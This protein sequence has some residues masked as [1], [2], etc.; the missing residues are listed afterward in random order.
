MPGADKLQEHITGTY[1]SLRIGVVVVGAALPVVLWLGGWIGDSQHL[2]AS[3]SAYYY[4]PTMG[5]VFVGTLVAVGVIL[6]LYKGFS[7]SEDWGLNLAGIFALGVA[8]VPM[9]APGAPAR[10]LTWHGTFA[11]LFFACIAYIC[12]FRAS[13]TLSLVR[14]TARAIRLRLVYRVLGAAMIGAPLLAALLAFVLRGA[15]GPSRVVFFVE[16]AGVWVFAAYWL[17]KSWELRKTGA[18]RL[19]LQGK[20]SRIA[21]PRRGQ[22]GAV[23]QVEPDIIQVE[24]WNSVVN[25]V[26]TNRP[27]V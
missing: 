21:N 11:V 8:L 6:F 5:D 19:A 4:S 13:D 9:E 12:I 23:I 3:M 10:A 2:R 26:S 16:A 14:D 15:S 7:A 17:V 18:A 25:K 27:E 24:D 20:L 1:E 22:L